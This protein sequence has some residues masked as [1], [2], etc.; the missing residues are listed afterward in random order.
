MKT[1]LVQLDPLTRYSDMRLCRVLQATG[2]AVGPRYPLLRKR[3]Y[4]E[5]GRRAA[6]HFAKA[7]LERRRLI[8][9]LKGK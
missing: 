7:R 3:I 4:A 9:S 6:S 2:R 1:I 8:A 5:L